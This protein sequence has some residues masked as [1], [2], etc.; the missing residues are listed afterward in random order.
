M[1]HYVNTQESAELDVVRS[2][3]PKKM[4][5]DSEKITKSSKVDLSN[6][7]PAA[8]LSSHTFRGEITTLL[9]GRKPRW[10]W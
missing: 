7:H 4:F 6:C 5:G 1:H 2:L 3:M 8:D 9:S 10:V